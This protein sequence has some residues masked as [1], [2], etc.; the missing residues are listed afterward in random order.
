MSPNRLFH[1]SRTEKRGAYFVNIAVFFGGIFVKLRT[2]PSFQW[3]LI[4][5]REST[6]CFYSLWNEIYM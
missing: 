3:T 2:S 1:R 6:E 4:K 5:N